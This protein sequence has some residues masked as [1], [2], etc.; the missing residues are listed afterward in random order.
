MERRKDQLNQG[1]SWLGKSNRGSLD[2]AQTDPQCDH[3][4]WQ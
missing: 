1:L 4:L 3:V 2:K